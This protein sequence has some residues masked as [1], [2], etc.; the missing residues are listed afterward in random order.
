MIVCPRKRRAN[1]HI[2]HVAIVKRCQEV[3]APMV[4]RRIC[5]EHFCEISCQEV[6][7]CFQCENND[8]CNQ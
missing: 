4:L 7:K 2:E 8:P 6:T 1:G 5:W 3:T